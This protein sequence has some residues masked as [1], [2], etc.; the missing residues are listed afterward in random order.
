MKAGKNKNR[1]LGSFI[2]G[3]DI[4]GRPIS[5]IYKGDRTFKSLVGGTATIISVV[6]FLTFF[7]FQLKSV[8]D[9][10]STIKNSSYILNT[11]S[12]PISYDFNISNFDLGV[13]INYLLSPYEPDI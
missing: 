13:N 4:Y 10:Q 1:S 6:G 8:I 3:I 7:V 11:A 12:D 9:K 2:K 5:L